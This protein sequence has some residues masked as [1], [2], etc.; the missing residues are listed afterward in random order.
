MRNSIRLIICICKIIL[1]VS[2]MSSDCIFDMEG[3]PSLLEKTLKDS[4]KDYFR[5][6]NLSLD[7]L[8]RFSSKFS[9]RIGTRKDNDQ[10]R[11]DFKKF[12]QILNDNKIYIC[13]LWI[14]NR[15]YQP[16]PHQFISKSRNNGSTLTVWNGERNRECFLEDENFSGI[17]A[18]GIYEN[19]EDNK[20][21]LGPLSFLSFDFAGLDLYQTDISYSDI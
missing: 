17:V 16:I 6:K 20:E 11:Q 18:D 7:Q 19:D 13:V 9:I 10:K 12:I 3:Y 4:I 5:F 15:S 8:K 2:N 1:L 21:N 14:Y